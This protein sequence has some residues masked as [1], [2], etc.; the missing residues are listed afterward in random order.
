MPGHMAISP[1]T[2]L[3]PYEVLAPLGAGGMGEVYRARDTR[4]D[5]TVAIKILPQQLAATAEMR[6]RFEREARA[7][8]SL[9][10]PH[11]CALYD[12]G[13]QDG[14][15]YLVMEYLEGE[16]LAR[17]LE[18]GPLPLADL[19]RYAIEIADALDRAH[20]QGIVHRDL[21]PGNIMLTKAGAKLLD[22]GL[23]KP[24]GAMVLSGETMT[25]SPAGS[26]TLTAEGTI[27]G[28][29]QYMS[30]EQLEGKEADARSDIFS[31]GALLYE[32]ATGKRAFEGKSHAS[33]IAA[34]LER[35]PAP[36][37][38]VQPMTPPGLERLVK[39]CLAKEP[40]ERY[41]SAH[42]LKLQ[43]GWIGEA[44][45]QAGVPAPVVS[46]RKRR[47]QLAWGVA[48]VAL[49][50]VALLGSALAV[51]RQSDAPLHV[52]VSPPDKVDFDATGDFGG[53]PALSPQGDRIVFSAHG[54]N[55]PK[56]L[57]VRPL[58]SFAAQRLE[59]SDGA[60]HPFW[61]PDGRYI[62]FFAGGK[63]N[64]ILATGGPVVSLAD[65]LDPRGGS[66][67]STDVILFAPSYQGGLMQVSAGGGQAI[68]ATT[69]DAAKHTTHRW[70]S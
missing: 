27:V 42:D 26:R 47:L 28:T 32:M 70:P 41:Q 29:V 12:I 66:W 54:P 10:H 25:V 39:T 62:G 57:W 7:V 38:Q 22:F 63:L 4:L 24:G 36:I 56:A 43:L 1:G 3:G 9:N 20:R 19:L 40:E 53:P 68:P 16:T 52:E 8:S 33:L 49:A 45:S 44:G 14:T 67:C 18:K 48:A 65:A 37:S 21:K 35:E 30:P 60:M 46:G 6:Q 51:R 55:S 23:A 11:I 64:K 50:A 17:R 5:R 13:D 58:D 34:I 2:K 59:G 31:F 61:S 69:V 15:E